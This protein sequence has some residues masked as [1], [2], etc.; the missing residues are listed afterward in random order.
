VICNVDEYIQENRRFKCSRYN[1]R[2][3]DYRDIETCPLCT[4]RHKLR[5]C[6]SLQK[7]FNCIN[8]MTCNVY[9]RSNTVYTNHSSVEKN[10]AMEADNDRDF[11]TEEFK[12]S[13]GRVDY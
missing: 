9:N 6:T 13:L 5:E 3:A 4:G 11:T 12:Q 7:Y 2:L 8:C 10:C 1:S